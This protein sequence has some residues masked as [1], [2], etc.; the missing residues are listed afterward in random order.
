[1]LP[2]KDS[3]DKVIK[4]MKRIRDI[5]LDMQKN[6]DQEPEKVRKYMIEIARLCYSGEN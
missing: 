6:R 3:E 4:D 1:M 2:R 5:I